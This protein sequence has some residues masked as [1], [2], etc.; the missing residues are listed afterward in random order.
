MKHHVL[1]FLGRFNLSAL[2][3]TGIKP[4]NKRNISF[5]IFRGCPKMS[6][7]IPNSCKLN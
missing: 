4:I 1:F 7:A 6:D 3:K 2:N 5:D